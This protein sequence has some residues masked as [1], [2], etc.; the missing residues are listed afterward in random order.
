ML[1]NSKI[2]YSI[3]GKKIMWVARDNNKLLFLYRDKPIKVQSGGYH[4]SISRIS[5]D[6]WE[7]NSEL[8]PNLKFEDEPLEVGLVEV[9]S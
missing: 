8:F 9:K 5:G 6:C 2:G 1:V 3:G 4:R 7:I